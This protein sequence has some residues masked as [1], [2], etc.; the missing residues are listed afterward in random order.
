MC[1]NYG[2]VRFDIFL[3]LFDFFAHISG[4]MQVNLG[5]GFYGNRAYH[6][7]ILLDRYVLAT[8]NHAFKETLYGF[9]RHFPE[10]YS[11]ACSNVRQPGSDGTIAVYVPSTSFWEESCKEEWSSTKI[12]LL[13]NG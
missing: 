1:L 11:T 12:F 6:R 13:F 5:I 8:G 7:I 2:E 9:F 10:P 3:N 4:E